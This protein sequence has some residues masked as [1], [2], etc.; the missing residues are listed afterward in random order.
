MGASN[1]VRLFEGPNAKRVMMMTSCEKEAFQIKM[2]YLAFDALVMK[3]KTV[4]MSHAIIRYS[5]K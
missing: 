4:C 3:R 1:T 5:I 2:S